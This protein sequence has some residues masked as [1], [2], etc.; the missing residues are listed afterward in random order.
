MMFVNYFIFDNHN[1]I[2]IYSVLS[3]GRKK[4]LTDSY[5]CIYIKLY[6]KEMPIYIIRHKYS[7]IVRHL[8]LYNTCA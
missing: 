8:D 1:Y 3:I 4:T 5:M 2:S 7:Y 6:V